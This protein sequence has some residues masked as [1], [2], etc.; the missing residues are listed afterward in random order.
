MACLF[1][2]GDI[3]CDGAFGI[4]EIRGVERCAACLA[5]VAVGAG[6]MTVGALARDIAVGKKLAGFGVIE[7]HRCLLDKLALVMQTGKEFR[8]RAV[9]DVGRRPRIYIERYAQLLERVLD[10]LVIAVDDIL[11]SDT[12]GTRFYRDRHTVLVAAAYEGDF[13]SVETEIAGIYIGGDID[14]GE[15][16]DMDRSVG[17]GKSRSDEC[18]LIFFVHNLT[19][20]VYQIAK[21]VNF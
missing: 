4:D 20:A 18:A 8:G 14:T 3:A 2:N 5:L 21:V 7:L 16:A 15:M 19:S 9:V 1:Q 17:I 11:G 12:L 10:Y 6:I 13:A